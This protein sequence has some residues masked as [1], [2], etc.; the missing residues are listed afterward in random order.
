MTVI[1][2]AAILLLTSFVSAQE[3]SSPKIGHSNT[4]KPKLPVVDYYACPGTGKDP[5][6]GE[7]V[8]NVKVSQDDR[9]YPSWRGNAAPVGTLKAGEEVTVLNGVNVTRE[10]DRAVIKYANPLSPLKVGDAAL[11]YGIES[12]GNLV[13]WAKGI[14]FEVDIEAVAEKGQ[15]GFT[16]GFGPGGCTIDIVKEGVS[17][18]WVQVKTSTGLRG[19]VVAEKQNGDKR[20]YGNFA[21]LCHYGE[22]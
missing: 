16:A 7:T 5:G 6:K 20:W 13:F 3:G 17:E 9:M 15:C 12:D 18:W 10:P 14:W 8:P 1:R 4:P 11:G 21:D 22:D 2:F 19:W